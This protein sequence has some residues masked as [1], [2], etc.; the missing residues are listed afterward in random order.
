MKKALVLTLCSALFFTPWLEAR[1]GRGG[2][3]GRDGGRGGGGSRNINRSPSMNR[4]TTRSSGSGLSSPS[5]SGSAR[6]GSAL[7][8]PSPA[9]VQSRMQSQAQIAQ[10]VRGRVNNL[11]ANTRADLF[12]GARALD[13]YADWRQASNWLDYGWGYPYYYDDGYYYT[14]ETTP[15]TTYTTP[16]TSSAPPSTYAPPPTV[17]G[18][19]PLGIFALTD[20]EGLSTPT[21][22][23]ELFVTQQRTLGGTLYNTS[24]NASYPLEGYIDKATQAA[25][26][27]LSSTPNSPIMET[28]LFNLT[29][30]QTR[31]Q[32]FFPNGQIQNWLLVRVK[33]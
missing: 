12:R 18:N 31:A 6:S 20:E 24:L 4:A 23:V 15:T 7:T 3:G 33:A 27:Q 11:P 9:N 1:G 25:R 10:S 26:W 29:Q 21:L 14:T 13:N 32:I 5:L 28:G 2:G 30:D 8:S 19:L 17:Q 22:Y 16:T